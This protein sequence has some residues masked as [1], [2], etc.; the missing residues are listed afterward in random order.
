MIC[1]NIDWG[2]NV[3]LENEALKGILDHHVRERNLMSQFY[4]APC[5]KSWDALTTPSIRAKRS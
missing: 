1:M 3:V 2:C 4:G 5:Q